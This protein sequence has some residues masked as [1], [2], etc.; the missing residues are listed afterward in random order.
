[1]ELHFFNDNGYR[2][3]VGLAP[4]LEIKNTLPGLADCIRGDVLDG[5]KIEF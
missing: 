2:L 3:D 1:L 4:T 5:V